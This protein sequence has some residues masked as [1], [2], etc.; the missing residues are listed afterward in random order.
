MDVPLPELPNSFK[1]VLMAGKSLDDNLSFPLEQWL[2]TRVPW[3]TLIN[4]I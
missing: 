3:H 4:L 1:L 2:P